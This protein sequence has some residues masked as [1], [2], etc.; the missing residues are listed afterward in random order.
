MVQSTAQSDPATSITPNGVGA[1]T[2]DTL[3]RIRRS[4]LPNHDDG[5]EFLSGN[6]P[7]EQTPGQRF[8]ALVPKLVL[9][10]T[11]VLLLVA[12][13]LFAFRALYSD[14]IYPAVVVGDVNVGGLTP[15]EANQRLTQRATQLET[16][17]ISYSYGDQVWTPTLSEI[18]ASMDLESSLADAEALGRTGDA[19]QRLSFTSELLQEDQ[20]VPLETSL[21]RDVLNAWFDKVDQDINQF[22]V[23]AAVV[24]NGSDISISPDADGTIVDREAATAQIMAALTN[25][26]PISAE[27]PTTVDIPEIR[28]ADLNAVKDEV[29]IAVSTPIR[30][31]FENQSWLVDGE[32]LAKYASAETILEDGRPVAKLSLDIETLA[33]DLR[34]EFGPQ[35]NRSPVDAR[36]GWQDGLVALDP[37][38]TGIELRATAFA[39]A[40][41]AS[42]LSGHE[43]VEVPVVEVRPKIDDENLAALGII[44]LLG[45]GDSTFYNGTWARDENINVA[46]SL[47]NGTL[48]PPGGIFS[49]NGAIGEI[50]ADK[51]YQE[52]SVVVAEQVGRDIGG[53]VCQVSTTVFRAALTAGMPIAE[54]HPH[55]FRLPGYEGADWP[56]GFDA[57]I[58]QWGGDP[59]AWGDFKFE[60][61]SDSWLLVESWVSGQ[62]MTVNIYGTSD[63]RQVELNSWGPM[64]GNDAAFTRVVTDS[65]GEVIA[66]REFYSDFK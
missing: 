25:L 37:S 53:G 4:I 3:D 64:E 57:S 44:E 28:A 14:R 58:L 8:R 34:A 22:A 6:A 52:A 48:V 60:N 9:G 20:I 23:N 47:L 63:G 35:I 15:V 51:G 18:G 16:S 55:T 29:K 66:E 10:L 26:E 17:T 24:V 12:I 5:F 50:T 33:A 41:E 38:T 62:T 2:S 13:A 46:T 56:A 49:F 45:R 11:A 40:L 30:V 42:F 43:R 32:T 36:V 21:D 7:L 59:S 27:I 54:W 19:V 1:W 65:N 39:E 31:M 61:Y